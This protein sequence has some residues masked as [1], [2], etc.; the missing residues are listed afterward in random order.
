MQRFGVDWDGPNVEGNDAAID[1]P[2]TPC[3][4][5]LLQYEELMR[6][7]PALAESTNYG[8]DLYEETLNFV[9]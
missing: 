2:E 1:V 3:P 6:L 9:F 5:S 8:I 7:V 4:L